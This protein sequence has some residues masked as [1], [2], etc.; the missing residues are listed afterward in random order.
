MAKSIQRQLQEAFDA[1][2]LTL[3][4]LLRLANLTCT[5]DSMSRKIRGKQALRSGEVEAL[6][7]ALR[8]EVVT[9]PKRGAA[10]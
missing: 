4:Q 3:D 9:G 2:G 5:A 8:V 1:S 7:R 6:A 10:A